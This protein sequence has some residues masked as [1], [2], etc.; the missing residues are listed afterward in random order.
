MSDNVL[1][2]NFAELLYNMSNNYTVNAKH[3]QFQ[4]GTESKS[5]EA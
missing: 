3:N 1:R 4:N 5:G 2:L